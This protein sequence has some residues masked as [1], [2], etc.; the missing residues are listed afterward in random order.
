MPGTFSFTQGIV[1]VSELS[2]AELAQSVIDK[3][4]CLEGTIIWIGDTGA[5]QHSSKSK[6]GAINIRN[7]GQ[8][9]VGSTGQPQTPQCTFDL[10]GQFIK[11]DGSLGLRAVITDISYS[12]QNNFNLFSISCMLQLGWTLGGNRHKLTLTSLDS[13]RVIHFD[14]VIKTKLGAVYAAKFARSEEISAVNTEA[15]TKMNINRAHQLLGHKSEANTRKSAKALGIVITRGK[16]EVCEAC[17]LAKAKQKDIPKKPVSE[18]V[19]VPLQRVRTRT[20]P[21]SK[22]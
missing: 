14:I 15:G 16:M 4:Q 2:A 9:S 18:K 5:S 11:H 17:A 19:E 10:P 7:A 13:K 21:K 1:S 22:S 6:E 3:I 8:T 20:Y 12:S